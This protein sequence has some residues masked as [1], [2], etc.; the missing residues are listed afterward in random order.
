MQEETQARSSARKKGRTKSA[1]T[2]QLGLFEMDAAPTR[3]RPTAEPPQQ[4]RR[5]PKK[6]APASPKPTPA[7]RGDVRFV[8]LDDLPDYP[9]EII[10]MV[11]SSIAAL[12]EE[13]VWL[14]YRDIRK[15]FGI[16]RATIARRLKE[17][18]VPGVRFENGRVLDDGPVRRFDRTQLRWLLLAVRV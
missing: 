18:V 4:M 13:L 12:P 3:A 8:K 5:P 7:P 14:T 9:P 2:S 11:D 1:D 6:T 16:S 10:A 15:R 17:G